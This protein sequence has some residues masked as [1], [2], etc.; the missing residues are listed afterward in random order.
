MSSLYV[1]HISS[2]FDVSRLCALCLWA[3]LGNSIYRVW[4]GRK[5][6]IWDCLCIFFSTYLPVSLKNQ[7]SRPHNH[8]HCINCFLVLY[9]APSPNSIY[10]TQNHICVYHDAQT[11]AVRS[12]RPKTYLLDM[13]AQRN[14]SSACEFAQSDKNLYWVHFG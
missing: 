12:Q 4:L 11:Q 10:A 6:A 9:R 5:G 2:C 14:S 8:S 3:F 13:Y 7:G 1:I